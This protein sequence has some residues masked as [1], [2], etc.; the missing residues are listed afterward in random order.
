MKTPEL[1]WAVLPLARDVP[2]PVCCLPAAGESIKGPSTFSASRKSARQQ[3]E[4]LSRVKS[5][6]PPQPSYLPCWA[7]FAAETLYKLSTVKQFA[8]GSTFPKKGQSAKQLLL[9]LLYFGCLTVIIICMENHS[10]PFSEST[11]NNSTLSWRTVKVAHFH[12]KTFLFSSY[13]TL[14]PFH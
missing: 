4:N 8:T 9:E 12:F 14:D 1:S 3:C 2:L 6:P 5:D 7:A 10:H 11:H 13:L